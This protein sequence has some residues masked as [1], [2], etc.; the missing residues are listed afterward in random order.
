MS[1]RITVPKS[2]VSGETR[3]YRFTTPTGEPLVVHVIYKLSDR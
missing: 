3:S 1:V 2:V